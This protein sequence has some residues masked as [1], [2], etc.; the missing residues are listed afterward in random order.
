MNAA[1]L[2]LDVRP[3]IERSRPPM[4]AILDALGRLAPAQSLRLVAPFEPK[5]LFEFMA[6]RGF[7]HRA[8]QRQDGAWEVLFSPYE[9]PPA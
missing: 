4:P 5:P 6:Q 2:E 7:T 9:I 3:L 1:P 8:R